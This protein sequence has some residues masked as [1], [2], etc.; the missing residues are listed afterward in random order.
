MWLAL[1]TATDRASV[2]LGT[3]PGDVIEEEVAGARRHAAAL[4]PMVACLL[5]R[6]GLGLEAVTGLALADG[7]GS[8]TGL[9]VGASLAKALAAAR[10]LPLW[11]APSLLVRAAGVA[12]DGALVLAVADALRGDVYA[13]LYRFHPGR[14]DTVLPAV[15]RR[16][17]AL[18]AEAPVPD[19]LVGDAP[20]PVVHGLEA[21]AGRRMLRPPEGAP[22]ART[23]IALT[24]MAGG[25]ARIEAVEGWQPEYG[26]PAEAQARWETAHGRPLPDSSGGPR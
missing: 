24:G 16:P 21:W 1:D 2:A 3:G 18:A 17:E 23:L 22:H 12:V 5:A 20:D 26:R 10:G 9:R 15:V 25:A 13:G 7:P 8:F 4:I 6:R 14:V 11:T 19:I